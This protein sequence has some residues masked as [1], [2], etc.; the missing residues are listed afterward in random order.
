MSGG[1]EVKRQPNNH[2]GL[3]IEF[4]G[5]VFL[6]ILTE[7]LIRD[8]FISAEAYRQVKRRISGEETPRQVKRRISGEETPKQVKW[9]ISGRE[10]PRQV[11]RCIS[12]KKHRGK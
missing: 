12:A 9:C 7:N 3:K 11:K 5:N 4:H 2:K 6:I 8:Y 10:T 1:R